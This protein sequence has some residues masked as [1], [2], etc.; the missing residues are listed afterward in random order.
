MI[1]SCP[2]QVTKRMRRAGRASSPG[3]YELLV[4]V[5]ADLPSLF[6]SVEREKEEG[7]PRGPMRIRAKRRR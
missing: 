3:W 6:S 1:P 2:C 5:Q 7:R 4:V